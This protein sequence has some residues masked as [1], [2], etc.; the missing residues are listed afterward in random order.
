[1][2]DT[3]PTPAEVVRRR[4]RRE[5][6]G[7]EGCRRWRLRLIALSFT[8]TA[9]IVLAALSGFSHGP[10]TKA[11]PS[12]RPSRLGSRPGR[13][14]P[15]PRR[16]RALLK[17]KASWY[18]DS[19][20]METASGEIF[21]EELLTAAMRRRALLGRTVRVTNLENGRTVVVRVND[22]GPHAR[23]ASRVIDL[24]R[25][26]FERIGPLDSGLLP[27]QVEVL[28]RARRHV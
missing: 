16:P 27:V 18:G 14:H 10:S 26:A 24:S 23:L 20:G 19:A 1:M 22:Y 17:G 4:K 2:G 9:P 25:A 6:L 21:H 28:R 13:R 15:R 11:S 8:L 3:T 7:D 5:R 12:P